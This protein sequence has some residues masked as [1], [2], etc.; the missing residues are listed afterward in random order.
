MALISHLRSV[1][2]IMDACLGCSRKDRRRRNKE[3]GTL[4]VGDDQQGHNKK[5]SASN[6]GKSWKNRVDL[7]R[8]ES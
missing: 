7:E 4:K 2:V 3:Q 5:G 1:P 6:G 8:A